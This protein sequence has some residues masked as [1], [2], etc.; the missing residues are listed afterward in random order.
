M[1]SIAT[2]T[3]CNVSAAT[4]SGAFSTLDTV[5]GA[6]PASLATSVIRALPVPRRWRRCSA[7]DDDGGVRAR[8]KISAPLIRE[9]LLDMVAL[10]RH[11]DES[12]DEIP[13]VVSRTWPGRDIPRLK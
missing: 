4:D 3:R 9:S 6:T 13:V 5:I 2:R 8:T 12:F 7:F 11:S 10:S 1:R